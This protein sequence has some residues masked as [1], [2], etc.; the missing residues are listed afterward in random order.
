MRQV[1]NEV[2]NNLKKV[3]LKNWLKNY[4]IWKEKIEK[5]IIHNDMINLFDLV[6]MHTMSL[7]LF[8]PLS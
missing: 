7:L 4:L 3:N 1:S 2:Q 5:S 8:V 6:I